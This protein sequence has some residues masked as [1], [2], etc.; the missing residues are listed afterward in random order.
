MKTKWSL[1]INRKNWPRI[2][3]GVLFTALVLV[4]IYYGRE[5][6]IANAHPPIKL[7]VFAF[8]TQKE[9]LT[10]GIIP[11][12]ERVWE[13]ETGQE[14]E[15]E[16][17][18]GPSASLAGQIDLGAPADIAIF[19]NIRHVRW[20]KIGRMVNSKTE[21]IIVGYSP[22][23][24]VTRPG[25]P[26]HISGFAD[27]MRPDIQLV[28]ADPR[29][30]GAGEWSLLAEYGSALIETN[31]PEVAKEQM[32]TIWNN[33]KLLGDSAR[34]II[35]LFE[36]GAGDV[37]ITYEQDAR[38]AQERGALIEVVLPNTTINTENVAVIIDE[39]V[40]QSENKA[41]NAFMDYLLSKE[42]Q[43]IFAKYN[44]R[45]ATFLYGDFPAIIRPFTI[46]EIGGWTQAYTQLVERIWEQ[47]FAQKHDLGL[48]LTLLDSGE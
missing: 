31:D 27:L 1:S 13:A 42:S 34:S 39:N 19:S 24:I 32:L 37:L 33:V 35:S 15:V 46:D 7:I 25:N 6:I 12:F 4:I 14:I 36:L 10:E 44:M 18:F 8:S 5:A 48:N 38:L 23:V 2:F 16:A 3:G 40:N 47:E 26:H 22:M 17:V 28:H 11:A 41:V 29:S 30:S 21:P 43:Q 45:P 9:V 20:L